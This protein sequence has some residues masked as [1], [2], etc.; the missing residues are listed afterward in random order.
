MAG[1]AATTPPEGGLFA[2]TCAPNRRGNVPPTVRDRGVLVSQA[3][4]ARAE[5]GLSV[6]DTRMVTIVLERHVKLVL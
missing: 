5:P 2:I 4:E 6:D 1:W 3:C